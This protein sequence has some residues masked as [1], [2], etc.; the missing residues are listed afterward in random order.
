MTDAE[1]AALAEG[2][3]AYWT[4]PKDSPEREAHWWAPERE[5]DL[6]REEPDQAWILILEILRRN[7]TAEILE[8]LSAG[9]LEDL[10]AKHGNYVIE[11]V[12]SEAKSNPSFATLLGGV[13][14]NA[15]ADDIWVRVQN[16][17]DRRGWDG[18]PVA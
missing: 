2:W 16:V 8:V 5:Y 7:N 1:L 9:P 17:W 4:A 10:L 6:V 11:R 14:K 18:I 15:M 13:W 3:I 12:E